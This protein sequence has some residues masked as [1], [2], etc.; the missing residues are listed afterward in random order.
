M[1]SDLATL[2]LL[3]ELLGGAALLFGAGK[4]I[5]NNIISPRDSKAE[6]KLDKLKDQ[7]QFYSPLVSRVERADFKKDRTGYPKG[8]ITEIIRQENVEKTYKIM[9]ESELKE[10]LDQIIGG[11]L[12]GWNTWKDIHVAFERIVLADFKKLQEK[13]DSL[14][15]D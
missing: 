8:I 4:W 6:F 12:K 1:A 7:L 9:A 3:I 5:W 14:L 11:N 15:N 13:Y 10:L 2:L